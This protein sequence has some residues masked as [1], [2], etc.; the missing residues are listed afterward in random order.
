MVEPPTLRF[1]FAV[2]HFQSANAALQHV[3]DDMETNP[4]QEQFALLHQIVANGD[5]QGLDEQVVESLG[6][7]SRLCIIPRHNQSANDIAL[8]TYGN[9]FRTAA[10]GRQYNALNWLLLNSVGGQIVEQRDVTLDTARQYQDQELFLWSF[11]S[12]AKYT[13]LHTEINYDDELCGWFSQVLEDPSSLLFH[14]ALSTQEVRDALQHNDR[15]LH[16]CY[17]RVNYLLNNGPYPEALTTMQLLIGSGIFP[18]ADCVGS[19]WRSAAKCSNSS[20]ALIFLLNL[21]NWNIPRNTQPR[22]SVLKDLVTRP[23]YQQL[24]ASRVPLLTKVIKLLIKIETNSTGLTSVEVENLRKA[25]FAQDIRMSQTAVEKQL[26]DFLHHITFAV[27]RKALAW[28]YYIVI[29][30]REAPVAASTDLFRSTQKSLREWFAAMQDYLS[31]TIRTEFVNL[32]SEFCEMISTASR[33]ATCPYSTPLTPDEKIVLQ[34]TCQQLYRLSLSVRLE[35]APMEQQ[36]AISLLIDNFQLD[37]THG[38]QVLVSET[39]LASGCA[40]RITGV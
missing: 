7:F 17:E 29:N 2:E 14:W 12:I 20:I 8:L 23:D 30:P 35:N 6:L 16:L 10:Q 40:A 5:I 22:Q 3:D 27:I 31:A 26:Y 28:N 34:G 32:Y 19:L 39:V 37:I 21:I 11:R 36:A 13:Q 9:L 38:P 1:G 25:G 24:Q 15:C 18:P 4:E 33:Q